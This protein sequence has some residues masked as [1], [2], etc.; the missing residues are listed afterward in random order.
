MRLSDSILLGT[1]FDHARG[2]AACA[3]I[4]VFSAAGAPLAGLAAGTILYLVT[5]VISAIVRDMRARGGNPNA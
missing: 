5:G 4:L 2:L 3:A 1:P